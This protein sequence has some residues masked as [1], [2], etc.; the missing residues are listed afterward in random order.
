MKRRKDWLFVFGVVWMVFVIG[1][2]IVGAIA[3]PDTTASVGAP[4]GAPGA[5]GHLLGTDEIGR[6]FLARIAR[7]AVM[8]LSIGL[9]VQLIVT[10]LGVLIGVLGEF[11]P[12]WIAIPLLRLTDAMFAFPDILLAI[13]IVGVLNDSSRPSVFAG[14]EGILPV[15]VALSIAGWPSTA[16]I[17]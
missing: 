11:G 7:G 15:V 9:I 1:L 6:D 2:A 4:H 13:L 8:S 16:R 5:G 14:I 17:V 10:S 12:K 3:L